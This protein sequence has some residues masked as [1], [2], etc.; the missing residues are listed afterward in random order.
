MRKRF[1][2]T[3][4]GILLILFAVALVLWKLDVWNLPLAL[5]G[6]STWGLF[7]AIIMIFAIINNIV[8]LNWGGIFFPIAILCIIFDEAL[9]ITQLTPWVVL[10]VALLLTVAFENLFP[11]HGGHHHKGFDITVN[12][13]DVKYNHCAEVSTVDSDEQSGYIMYM[14]RFGSATRYVRSKNLSTSDL[15]CSFGSLSVFF[16]DVAVPSGTVQI[17]ARVSFGELCIYIPRSWKLENKV[18]VALGDCED[19]NRYAPDDQDP[20]VCVIDGNVSFGNLQI[21]RI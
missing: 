6:V 5:A 9:G 20:V 7:L 4:T 21:T 15:Q 17:N 3:F 8:E 13:D 12:S 11:K 18:S 1:G 14:E 19:D 2:N 10:I 16:D